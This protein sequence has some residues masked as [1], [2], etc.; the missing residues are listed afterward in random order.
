MISAKE[1]SLLILENEEAFA[2]ALAIQVIA[3]P[4]LS[5]WMILIPIIF[6]YFFY[7]YDKCVSGRKNFAEN[8]MISRKRSVSEAL[9]ATETGSL[10]DIGEIISISDIPE[11]AR[12][13]YKQWIVLLVEHYTELLESEGE[14]FDAL[15]KS[16]Y[17]SRTNFLLFINQLNNTEKKL[18]L[19][20]RPYLS[21]ESEA[22]E[23]DRV[24]STIEYYSEALR[25]EKA[26][27]IFA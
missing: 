12:N 3:G 26:E 5:I 11:A 13:T 1:K 10:A 4:K 16:A 24:V 19:A 14:D 21:N 20:L 22:E 23:T 25:R 27:K 7:E 15:V 17:G 6:V 8:Y 9:A 18:N 2:H